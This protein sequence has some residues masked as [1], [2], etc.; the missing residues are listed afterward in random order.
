MTKWSIPQT[1]CVQHRL[2][3]HTHADRR[4][5]ACLQTCASAPR[6]RP[7]ANA[8]WMSTTTMHPRQ[9]ETTTQSRHKDD[10]TEYLCIVHKRI[11]CYA[12]IDS[13]VSSL[14]SIVSIRITDCRKDRITTSRNLTVTIGWSKLRVSQRKM[15]SKDPSPKAKPLC[16]DARIP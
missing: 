9:C 11:R 7:A 15:G 2:M 10:R 13:L 1:P 4:R 16:N 6:S 8:I 14:V 3:Y 12:S 5:K